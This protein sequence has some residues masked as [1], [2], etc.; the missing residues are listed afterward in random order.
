MKVL[1]DTHVWVWAA[2]RSSSLGEGCR[3]ILLH[4]DTQRYVSPVS[5]LE[6]AR[7]V[8]RS[9]LVIACSLSEWIS[10]SMQALK[11]RTVELD[12]VVAME[13]YALPGD[14]HANPADRQLVATA[15]MRGLVLLTADSRILAYQHVRAMNATR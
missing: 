2:H 1:L 4:P 11:L 9:E 3:E 6:I 15:R 8:A 13:A 12:H 7:L 14:F 10:K 5:T